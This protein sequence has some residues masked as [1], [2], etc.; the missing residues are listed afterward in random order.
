MKYGVD[1]L[2][3]RKI[4]GEGSSS[5]ATRATSSS[6]PRT[7]L[8]S[9]SKVLP[10]SFVSVPVPVPVSETGRDESVFD[11]DLL[12]C[13]ICIER[14]KSPIYQVPCLYPPSLAGIHSLTNL[15]ENR[16]LLDLLPYF[17]GVLTTL[18]PSFQYPILAGSHCID[19]LF[20]PPAF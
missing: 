5:L 10:S 18:S 7:E 1:G 20:E 2:K 9:I 3:R 17:A 6:S 11:R 12:D 16:F 13:S 14:L 15:F 19:N 4:G 8:P